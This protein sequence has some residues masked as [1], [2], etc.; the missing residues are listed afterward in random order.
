MS[1]LAI[2]DVGTSLGPSSSI[3]VLLA[4]PCSKERE[5]TKHASPV[6]DLLTVF[7]TF[8]F[9]KRRRFRDSQ[10]SFV[11]LRRSDK[12][13][14]LREQWRKWVSIFQAMVYRF[15]QSSQR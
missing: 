8:P 4:N 14:L 15:P 2:S 9:S 11:W 3:F 5:V 13:R 12:L 1:G 7:A 10:K 6:R